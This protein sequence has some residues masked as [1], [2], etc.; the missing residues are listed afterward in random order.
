GASFEVGAN[1]FQITGVHLLTA[2]DS[3]FL[4]INKD[5]I[6]YVLQQAFLNETLFKHSAQLLA[7]FQTEVFELQ[8][9]IDDGEESSEVSFEAARE[10][11]KAWFVELLRQI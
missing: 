11:I 2:S 4:R 9:R 3:E 6:L 5:A 1:D 7:D 10:I 8:A